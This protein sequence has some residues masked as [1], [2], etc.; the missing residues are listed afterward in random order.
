VS[1]S[2]RKEILASEYSSEQVLAV[3]TSM[4]YYYFGNGVRNGAIS[5]TIRDFINI[6]I[7]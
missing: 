3:N 1:K 7:K 5:F 4:C 2:V 6:T